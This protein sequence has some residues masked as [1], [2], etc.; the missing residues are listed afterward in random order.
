MQVD[1]MRTF[2]QTCCAF[3]Q[4]RNLPNVPY[5]IAENMQKFNLGHSGADPGI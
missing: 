5:T 4:M 3:G 2:E 1:Q